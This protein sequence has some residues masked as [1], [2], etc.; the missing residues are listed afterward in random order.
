MGMHRLLGVFAVIPCSVLLTIS[1]FVLFA[2]RKVEQKELKLFGFA[3]AVMLWISAGLVLSCGIFHIVTGKPLMRP[4]CPMMGMKAGHH[5]MYKNM[6]SKRDMVREQTPPMAKQ[7]IVK[8]KDV[9]QDKL[10]CAGNKG[11]IYKAE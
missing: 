5:K 8:D 7:A 4:P 3:V 2:L 10:G 11:V 6:D 1:F 9:N